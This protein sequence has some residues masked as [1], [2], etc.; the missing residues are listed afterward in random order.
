MRPFGELEADVMDRIWSLGH[1]CTVREMREE[2][3]QGRSLA[4]TTVMT[5][6]DNLHKKGWLRRESQGRA[7]VYEPVLGREEYSARI[8]NEAL[9]GSADPH[10]TLLHFVE[11]MP[12]E[13]A[14]E[15]RTLL[16]Q[17]GRRKR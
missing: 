6:M 2:L 1:G 12:P 15:L 13:D 16:Q 14:R 8:M 7:Y 11:Q 4:Y 3:N 17:L 9:S 10:A 5:V